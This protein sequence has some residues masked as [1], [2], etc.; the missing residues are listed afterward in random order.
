MLAY[1]SSGIPPRK[2]M[3]QF[4]PGLGLING[5]VVDQHF[6]ARGRAGRLMTAVAHNPH[7][8]GLGLDE[9][10]AVEVLHNGWLTVLGSGS[11]MIID[12]ISISHTD[13]HLTAEHAPLTIFDMRVHVLS[14]GYSYNLQTRT[15]RFPNGIASPEEATHDGTKK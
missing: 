6:G 2:A 4:A 1:G 14:Q 8:L 9:D 13:I 10:T 5:V 12:G 7:L 11:V 15:P 3:M